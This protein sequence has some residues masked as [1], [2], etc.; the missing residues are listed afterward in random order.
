M[1]EQ[2][3]EKGREMYRETEDVV[4]NVLDSSTERVKDT[5]SKVREKASDL[6][7]RGADAIYEARNLEPEK[8]DYSNFHMQRA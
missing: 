4:K 2:T 1:Y 8:M 6:I 7:D 3:A 5:Y